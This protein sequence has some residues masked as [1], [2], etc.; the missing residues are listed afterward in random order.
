MLRLFAMFALA[1]TIV[2]TL[3]V[4]ETEQPEVLG[5][6]FYADWCGSCKVLDPEIQKARGK[7]NLDHEPVLFVRLDLTDATQRYQAGLM[8]SSLGLGDFYEKNAGATGFM[9]LVDAETKEVISMLTKTMD[10]A[11]ITSEVKAAIDKATG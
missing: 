11:A 3:A 5:V 9:L 7:S 2:P 8:A 6:L 4:A 10:A 1:M